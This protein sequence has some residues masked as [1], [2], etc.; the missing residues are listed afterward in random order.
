MIQLAPSLVS[1]YNMFLIVSLTLS[2]ILSVLFDAIPCNEIQILQKY[3]LNTSSICIFLTF[4]LKNILNRIFFKC[5]IVLSFLFDFFA[6][7]RRF[8]LKSQLLSKF[9]LQVSCL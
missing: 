5:L 7:G 6:F 2:L 8:L 3:G 9:S 4:L 1:S